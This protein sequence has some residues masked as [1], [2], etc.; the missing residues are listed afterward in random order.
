MAQEI[1]IADVCLFL[2]LTNL[3][4]CGVSHI[5]NRVMVLALKEVLLKG[6]DGEEFVNVAPDV[7]DA[8]L[9]PCPYLRRDVVVYFGM[10][11]ER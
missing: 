2:K 3:V 9:L 1:V 7:L 10:R 4:G 5:V 11:G 6:K 8:V